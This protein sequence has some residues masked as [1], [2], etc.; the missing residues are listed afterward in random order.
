MSRQGSR[1]SLDDLMAESQGVIR[2]LIKEVEYLNL[3][4][5]RLEQ[6]VEQLTSLLDSQ[7]KP[8]WRKGKLEFHDSEPQKE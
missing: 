2:K 3:K 7:F 8:K 5:E 1:E 4:N 6:D